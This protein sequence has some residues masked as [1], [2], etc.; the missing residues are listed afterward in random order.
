DGDYKDEL[1]VALI[2]ECDIV[3]TN[4]AFS[5]KL[6][7]LELLTKYN[8]DYLVI[9]PLSGVCSGIILN[10]IK[11][12]KARVGYNNVDRFENTDKQV[13]CHWYTSLNVNKQLFIPTAHYK[14]IEHNIDDNDSI[15]IINKVADI[16]CDYFDKMYVPI[17]YAIKHNKDIFNIIKQYSHCFLNGK[18]L[19]KRLLIQRC[20]N[21]I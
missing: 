7:L 13:C 20:D 9:I 3:I 5:C 6:E 1:G 12:N 21:N 11:N 15:L 19:F 2:K 18:S 8:K 16:L 4:P 10:N 17:T 14:D